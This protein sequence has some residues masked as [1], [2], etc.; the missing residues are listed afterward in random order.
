[1]YVHGG[2]YIFGSANDLNDDEIVNRYA[3]EDIVFVSIAYRLGIFGFIDLE[4]VI[5][6]LGFDGNLNL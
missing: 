6:N 3:T 1:M 4:G 2:A 5:P